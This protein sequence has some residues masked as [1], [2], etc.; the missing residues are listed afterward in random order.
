M[1]QHHPLAPL[2]TWLEAFSRR[3]GDGSAW[4]PGWTDEEVA[5]DAAR[6]S[7]PDLRIGDTIVH[8]RTGEYHEI[9]NIRPAARDEWEPLYVLQHVNTGRR[10]Y[11]WETITEYEPY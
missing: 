3:L 10:S 2:E 1:T 6:K 9:M 11:V 5:A 7:P 4:T 8:T